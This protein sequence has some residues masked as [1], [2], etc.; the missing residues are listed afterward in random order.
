[1]GLRCWFDIHKCDCC[2]TH[3]DAVM[4]TTSD[5][6]IINITTTIDTNW[7]LQHVCGSN[8]GWRNGGLLQTT[9]VNAGWVCGRQVMITRRVL[10]RS[11]ACAGLG[12]WRNRAS[13]W[14]LWWRYGGDGAGWDDD[15]FNTLHSAI[16]AMRQIA[17]EFVEKKKTTEKQKKNDK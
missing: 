16:S 8:G 7:W 11:D 5:I 9:F 4:I 15:N 17:G 1:M 6:I 2:C 10:S 14:R 12:R 3:C 13:W